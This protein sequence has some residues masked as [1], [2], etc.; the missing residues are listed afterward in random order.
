MIDNELHREVAAD[1]SGRAWYNRDMRR[2]RLGFWATM[3]I[4]LG[5]G[6][7]WWIAACRFF[8]PP[9]DFSTFLLIIISTA[10]VEWAIGNP[11]LSVFRNKKS[12]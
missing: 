3:A 2:A 7:I 1:D 10:F 4:V 11:I 8:S 12:H 6:T 9:H 5:G